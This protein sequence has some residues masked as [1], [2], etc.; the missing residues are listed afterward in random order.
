MKSVLLSAQPK[1]CELTASGKKTVD[2]RKTRPKIETPF[3]CY[4]Y[5]T[6]GTDRLL[7]FSSNDKVLRTTKSKYINSIER[8]CKIFSGK[9]IGEFVCNKIEIFN[10]P[11]PWLSQLIRQDLRKK[12]CVPFGELY[13]YSNGGKKVLFAWHIS[14]L[15]IYDTPKELQEFVK[16]G[17]PKMEELDDA[18]CSYCYRTEYGEKKCYSYP[19]GY[20]SCEGRYCDEAY[21]KYLYNEYALIRAPQSWCYVEEVIK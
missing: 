12:S 19:G 18:L 5:C 9:V 6:K 2:V 3:K 8:T 17:Y 14:E 4:I 1:W 10:I 15:V 13:E 16:P 20:I 7:Y 21:D 11:H